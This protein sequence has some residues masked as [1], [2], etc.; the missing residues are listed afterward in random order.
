M[1]R[2]THSL[3]TDMSPASSG[4][5]VEKRLRFWATLRIKP[6]KG[7]TGKL[8]KSRRSEQTDG[9]WGQ[10]TRRRF[11]TRL[12]AVRHSLCLQAGLQMNLFHLLSVLALGTPI[13]PSYASSFAEFQIQL[14]CFYGKIASFFLKVGWKSQLET[15]YLNKCRTKYFLFWKL[16]HSLHSLLQYL[17]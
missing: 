16:K 1:I 2:I 17:W 13:F 12:A 8:L 10:V 6:P 4:S 14:Y 5:S 11:Q 7:L 9:D 3:Y 15:N